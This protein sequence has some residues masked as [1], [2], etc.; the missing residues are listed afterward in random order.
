MFPLR[1]RSG[2]AALHLSYDGNWVTT[3]V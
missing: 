2:H 1:C 3:A